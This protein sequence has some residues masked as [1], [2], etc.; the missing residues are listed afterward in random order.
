LRIWPPPG[1]ASWQFV[2][3]AILTYTGLAG[4]VVLG[5]IDWNGFILG[6]WVRFVIGGLLVAAGGSFGLWGFVT[7]GAHASQGLGGG[8]VTTGPYAWSRNPQYVG[9]VPVLVGYAVLCNSK[10]ALIAAMVASVWFV[11]APFAEEP[12][13]RARLG[14]SYEDYARKLPRFL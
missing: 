6:G 1:K 8:L 13:L 11:L 5:V 12:W 14:A 9:T 7:L 4:V 10:L 2:Y 3:G